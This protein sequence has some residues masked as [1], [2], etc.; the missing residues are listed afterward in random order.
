MDCGDSP[1]LLALAES[2]LLWAVLAAIGFAVI[3]VGIENVVAPAMMAQG[4]N[5]APAVALVSLVFWAWVL[6]PLGFIL[7]IPL[8]VIVVMLLASNPETEW[9]LALL[10][11]DSSP[12]P[13]LTTSLDAPLETETPS[14]G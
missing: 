2:G 10:T 12:P 3:N 6:G 7:A 11:T 13:P 4:L 8:T 5:L 9:L 14:L 1:I